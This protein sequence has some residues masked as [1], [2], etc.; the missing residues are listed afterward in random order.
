MSDDEPSPI[1]PVIDESDRVAGQR[2]YVY[3]CYTCYTR[4]VFSC[5]SQCLSIRFAAID[6]RGWRGR[7][8][9]I[10]AF[11]ILNNSIVFKRGNEA[12]MSAASE[13]I[14]TLSGF[15]IPW[16]HRNDVPHRNP[17]PVVAR[18]P[19]SLSLSPPFPST[20]QRRPLNIKNV[21]EF[22]FTSEF[23]RLPYLAPSTSRT[24]V[25]LYCD[26]GRPIFL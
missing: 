9:T 15:F 16:F 17:I 3:T 1:G 6:D 21:F 11:E 22:C 8:P 7:S 19:F 20:L 13:S 10:G 4:R 18:F 2:Y 25:K 14:T 12:R 5:L 24:N 26:P 23:R